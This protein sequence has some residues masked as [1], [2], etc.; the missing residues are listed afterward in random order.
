MEKVPL[1]LRAGCSGKRI[2]FPVL[3]MIMLFIKENPTSA[4]S[5]SQ[6]ESA[7]LEYGNPIIFVTAYFFFNLLWGVLNFDIA[8]HIAERGFGGAGV[9]GTIVSI[10]TL[11]SM[12]ASLVFGVCF[13][14]LGRSYSIIPWAIFALGYAALYFSPNVII[15][16]LIAVLMAGVYGGGQSFYITW[17]PMISKAEDMEKYMGYLVAACGIGFFAST[18]LVTGLQQILGTDTVT[19]T[20]P[21][22]AG[23]AA[24][25][26]LLSIISTRN[27][28]KATLKNAA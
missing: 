10:E 20:F 4:E 9:S 3:V 19:S 22:L 28:Y 16:T 21:L 24:V 26:L 27:Y 23:L 7:D 6:K 8:V 5:N 15:T 12:I 17:L 2:L 13:S 18:Y 11:G 14:K 1:P 25:L